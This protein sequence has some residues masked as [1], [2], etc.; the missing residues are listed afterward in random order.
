MNA[1]RCTHVVEYQKI[2]HWLIWNEHMLFIET[3]LV[4]FSLYNLASNNSFIKMMCQGKEK[5]AR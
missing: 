1:P 3:F 2:S 4:P 5:G